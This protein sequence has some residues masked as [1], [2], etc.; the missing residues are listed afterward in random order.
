[1]T[2]LGDHHPLNPLDVNNDG[3]VSVFD[4]LLVECDPGVVMAK[5]V[6]AQA[7]LR[8]VSDK[9]V[10]IAQH[11]VFVGAIGDVIADLVLYILHRLRI[12]G[13]D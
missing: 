12:E 9:H 11:V 8:K 10:G 7:N 1:M 6:A 4:T 2:A 3:R 5:A 13:G